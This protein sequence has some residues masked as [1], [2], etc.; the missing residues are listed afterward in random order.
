MTLK[1]CTEC[2]KE[3]SADANPCPHC[4]RKRPHATSGVVKL[5]VAALASVALL[6]MC[7][8]R[9]VG[10]AASP[11]SVHAADKPVPALPAIDVSAQQLADAYDANEIAADYTYKGR[12]LNISGNVSSIDKSVFGEPVIKLTTQNEYDHV[13][14]TMKK[15]EERMA[16]SLHKGVRIVVQC[17]GNGFTIGS[18]MLKDCSFAP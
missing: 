17:H 13:H 2:H 4:G 9:D 11:P 7:G 8:R 5:A 18:P 6:G 1:A 15:S 12:V 3:I 14:A 10:L 16:A